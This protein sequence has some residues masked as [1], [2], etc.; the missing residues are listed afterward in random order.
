MELAQFKAYNY[1][2]LVKVKPCDEPFFAY[3]DKEELQKVFK[4]KW[5]LVLNC[6]KFIIGEDIL[7][8]ELQRLIFPPNLL[9]SFLSNIFDLVQNFDTLK[10][11]ANKFVVS[12]YLEND[13]LLSSVQKYDFT[14]GEGFI[15]GL[16]PRHLLYYKKRYAE[17]FHGM[18]LSTMHDTS[19]HLYQVLKKYK[20]TISMEEIDDF[21]RKYHAISFLRS[22]V[23]IHD[24]QIPSSSKVAKKKFC[25]RYV[26]DI[27]KTVPSFEHDSHR[28][29]KHVEIEESSVNGL[30]VME[31]NLHLFNAGL[32]SDYH[33]PC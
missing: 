30:F 24:L 25:Y 27:N 5:K 26:P 3:I 28:K 29:G 1:R 14:L 10:I 13:A 33:F 32:F 19:A 21:K 7:H 6:I 11:F 17:I 12:A 16:F 8:T 2:V 20:S 15:G 31:A 4:V 22:R 23:C 18:L 9:S